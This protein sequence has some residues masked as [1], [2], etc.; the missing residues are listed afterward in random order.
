MKMFIAGPDGGRPISVP[1]ARAAK[2]VAPV[3]QRSNGSEALAADPLATPDSVLAA[4]ASSSDRALRGE[5]SVVSDEVNKLDAQ[6]ARSER[7]IRHELDASCTCPAH[8]IES[9]THPFLLL[10]GFSLIGP[11]LQCS[12]TAIVTG[13]SRRCCSRRLRDQQIQELRSELATKDLRLSAARAELLESHMQLQ[14][15]LSAT[16]NA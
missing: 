6:L 7:Q 16:L 12:T 1:S 5:L 14:V 10:R 3:L 2:P 11:L 8:M 13:T 9:H 4:A 15:H